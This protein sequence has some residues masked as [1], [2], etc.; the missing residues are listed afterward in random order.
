MIRSRRAFITSLAVVA[1]L[2]AG[3]PAAGAAEIYGEPIGPC[4]APAGPDG[5]GGTA[6]TNN[7]ICMGAGVASIGPSTGQIATVTGPVISGPGVVGASVVSA[8]NAA[9]IG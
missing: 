3:A 4:S 2:V 7:Q 6:G 9:A 5:Q 8:G 1:A